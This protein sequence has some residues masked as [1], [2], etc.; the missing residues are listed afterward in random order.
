MG[1][2]NNHTKNQLS[3]DFLSDMKIPISTTSKTEN[4]DNMH[5]EKA[6]SKE[7]KQKRKALAILEKPVAYIA[8]KRAGK[9]YLF[10]SL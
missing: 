2:C 5:D 1:N 9:R 4:A 7:S 3:R 8:A 10:N 6:K